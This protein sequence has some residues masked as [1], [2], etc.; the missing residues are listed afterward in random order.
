MPVVDLTIDSSGSVKG[1]SNYDKAVLSSAST[2][3]SHFNKMRSS[4]NSYAQIVVKAAATVTTALVGIGVSSLSAASDMEETQGKFDVVFRGLESSAEGWAAKLAGSYGLAKE[5][6]KRYLS[7]IQD[8]IVPT[9]MVRD[10]AGEMSN[11]FV[12]MA[13]DLA[14]FNNLPT[15]KVIEDIQSALAG[16]SET[17]TKYG[18]NVKVAQVNQEALNMGLIKQGESLTSAQRVQVLYNIMLREGSDAMGDFARTT[19]SFAN[20]QKIFNAQLSD[21]RVEIGQQLLPI[22]TKFV[23]ALNKWLK[24]G[25]KVNTMILYTVKTIQFVSN[26]I[27]GLILAGDAVVVAFATI[28]DQLVNGFFGVMNPLNLLF[29]ALQKL[30]LVENNPFEKLRQASETFKESSR[31]VFK[32]QLKSIESSNAGFDSMIEKLEKKN[33]I[34]KESVSIQKEGLSAIKDNL[35]LNEKEISKGKEAF[36][37]MKDKTL[38]EKNL[39]SAKITTGN[40]AAS[41]KTSEDMILDSAKKLTS[42]FNKQSISAGKVTNEVNSTAMAYENLNNVSSGG[43][44]SSSGST[45]SYSSIGL[46]HDWISGSNINDDNKITSSVKVSP[47]ITNVFSQKLSRSDINNIVVEQQRLSVRT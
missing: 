36:E 12:Q 39:T 37:I 22:A 8:L 10:Q 45:N 13:V 43:S 9:G 24:E 16:G 11:K 30:G 1:L 19:D 2:T 42:E 33:I 6:G 18:I 21:M 32:E 40:E 17:L 5:E 20:Q 46:S 28:F 38:E 25:N 31:E 7:S 4:V 29:E 34:Q 26:G 15:K 23:T 47:K 41:V 27:K 3:D 14:S 44:Y 35:S